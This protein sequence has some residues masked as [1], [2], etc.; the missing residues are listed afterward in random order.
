MVYHR[1]T[2]PLNLLVQSAPRA[3]SIVAQGLLQRRSALRVQLGNT[4]TKGARLPWTGVQTALRG[5]TRTRT[6]RILKSAHARA[7]PR[8]AIRLPRA[9]QRATRAKLGLTTQ[10]R[11]NPP[12][13]NASSAAKEDSARPLGPV[14]RRSVTVV[15]R[16]SRPTK[17][18]NLPRTHALCALQARTRMKRR[19]S[20]APTVLKA[21]PLILGRRDA[22]LARL[23]SAGGRPR[24]HAK[25]A[26][27][28]GTR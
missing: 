6:G 12:K 24:K 10:R 26:S 17:Q 15:P 11:G 21:P 20:G 8:G 28:G 1:T 2:L 27:Q 23:A 5:N 22:E 3:P 13:T 4:A 25:I 7:V 16:A 18:D 14:P 19:A 9:K